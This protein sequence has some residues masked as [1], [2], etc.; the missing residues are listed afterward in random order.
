MTAAR[1][2]LRVP[3]KGTYGAGIFGGSRRGAVTL[4]IDTLERERSGGFVVSGSL[5]AVLVRS[6]GEK[7]AVVVEATF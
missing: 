1:A 4:Q 3:G 5:R 2:S 6:T 7:G